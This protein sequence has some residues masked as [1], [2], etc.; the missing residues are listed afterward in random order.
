MGVL[1]RG[2]PQ[3]CLQLRR[4]A[5]CITGLVIVEVEVGGLQMEQADRRAA[6]AQNSIDL[7]GVPARIAQ[8]EGAALP[9]PPGRK[10]FEEGVE[11]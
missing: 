4:V 8:L 5:G 7:L 1:H 2:A 11:S 9:R 10:D 3:P 6:P